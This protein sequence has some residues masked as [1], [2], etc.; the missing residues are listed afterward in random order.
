MGYPSE[1][2]VDDW[3]RYDYDCFQAELAAAEGLPL[4]E[5]P[6]A[7]RGGG[8]VFGGGSLTFV[9]PGEPSA[10]S[11]QTDPSLLAVFY[12][13]VKLMPM[14]AEA[15]QMSQELAKVTS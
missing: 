15:N 9:C 10:G 11:S 2:G 1:R 4:G 14:M 13:Y 6:R 12:D 7:Q 8:G 3:R 5:G